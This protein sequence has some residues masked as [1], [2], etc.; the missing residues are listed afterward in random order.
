MR[1]ST[2]LL[3]D[4][5]K[6]NSYTKTNSLP[7][8]VID[9]FDEEQIWQQID[10]QNEQ[11]IPFFISD[12]SKLLLNKELK[13]PSEESEDEEFARK[14]SN[15]F[16]ESE[17]ENDE[18]EEEEKEEESGQESDNGSVSEGEASFGE[19]ES[20]DFFK[21]KDK[22]RK[23]KLE[24]SI[25]DDKFFKMQKLNEYLLKED[26]KEIRGQSKNEDHSDGESI[27]LFN[28]YS[29]TDSENEETQNEKVAK[30]ADFF[31][32]PE[33]D[34]EG[35]NRHD[36]LDQRDNLLEEDMEGE[37]E[38]FEHSEDDRRSSTENRV[39]FNLP[40]DS[41]DSNESDGESKE[42]DHQQVMSSL[43][44]RR[45]RLNK[46]IE[47]REV[48][49]ISEKPWQLKGEVNASNRPQDS[50][51]EDFVEVDV[52]SRPPPVITEET[53]LKL[54][55]ILR[56]RIKDKAWDDVEKKVKPVDTPVE[57]KKKLIMDQE[58]SKLSL[59]QIYEKDF[60]KQR[61]ALNPGE[62]TEEADPP[63]HIEIKKSMHSLFKMLDALS[64]FHYTPKPVSI[65][66]LSISKDI[67]YYTI[68]Y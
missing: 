41:D 2:K 60:V 26:K 66:I 38:P 20:T 56:Q 33:S 35:E 65:S 61:E 44:K 59:A 16:K 46:E 17:D 3:Y 47:K 55:D 40:V 48:E 34:G 42:E 32:S 53:T 51:L 49:A 23:R 36:N 45:A 7:E 19:T 57:F 39:R 31:D 15:K 58:K 68:S 14:P 50:L 6:R 30:Y 62:K 10:L 5:T 22:P 1:K 11:A 27:D 8:L 37:G 25:V 67:M 13:H 4:F 21:S 54:E 9:G 29:D 24:S 43:E 12:I 28:G 52:V 63:E 18:E 64:N